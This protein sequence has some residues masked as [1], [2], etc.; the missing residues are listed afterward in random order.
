M[1]PKVQT[2]V[3]LTDP[4][5]SPISIDMAPVATCLLVLWV[6]NNWATP[7]GIYWDS[8]WLTEQEVIIIRLS[9]DTVNVL[10]FGLELPPLLKDAPI[11]PELV[12][13]LACKD[14]GFH[15]LPLKLTLNV[16]LPV[17]GF[18]R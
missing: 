16:L 13:L 14:I 11:P 3:K 9:W 12:K 18:K 17:G 1:L 10:V 15:W 2:A 8:I 7:V 4:A 6:V 5:L